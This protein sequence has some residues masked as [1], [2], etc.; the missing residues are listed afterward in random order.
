MDLHLQMVEDVFDHVTGRH[1]LDGGDA[2]NN[3][4]FTITNFAFTSGTM[5]IPAFLMESS[6]L[7]L[8]CCHGMKMAQLSAQQ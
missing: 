1:G 5:N 2:K 4:P 7:T 8:S 3:N 6:R